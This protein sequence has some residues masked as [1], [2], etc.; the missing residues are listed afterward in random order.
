MSDKNNNIEF[1]PRFKAGYLHPR[2]WGSWLA[3]G[4]L[5]LLTLIPGKLRDP[6][7]ACTAK[8]LLRFGKKA[9]R[10]AQ[11]NLYYCLPELSETQRNAI[12]E[13]MFITA[14]QAMVLMAELALFGARKI[15]QRVQWHNYH[16]IEDLQRTKQNVIFLVPHGWAVDI[17]AMLL[18]ASGQKMA[19]MFQNQANQ[20]VDYLWNSVRRRF[21]G[22]LH[23]RKDGIKPFI[24][25][26]RN[27]YWGYYLP[28]E[29]YGVEHSHFVDFFATY[30]ATLPV[31]GRLMKLCRARV[32]PLF[33]VYNGKTHQL[34]IYIRPPMDDLSQADEPT[35]ARRMNEEVE[36]L[37]RP[38]PEQYT[39][40]LKLLKT[41]LPGDMEPYQREDLYPPDK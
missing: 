16:I 36:Q 19:A 33:P 21:N 20:V 31:I 13:Q 9:R 2:Y 6:L 24:S 35:I 7:L 23:A 30:K 40:I 25:S 38:H 39:W 26:M 8:Q 22:R 27:G 12:I 29:D 1:I 41:R 14:P 4:V 5:M 15:R 34:D 18:T 11:I 28:D 17:P 32:V 37:V 10:R 3:I